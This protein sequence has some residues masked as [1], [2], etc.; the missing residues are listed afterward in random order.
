M[1]NRARNLCGALRPNGELCRPPLANLSGRSSA[2]RGRTERAE[3]AI[4]TRPARGY[5]TADERAIGGRDCRIV[6]PTYYLRVRRVAFERRLG[7]PGI[8][9]REIGI[10]GIRLG[11]ISLMGFPRGAAAACLVDKEMRR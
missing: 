10:G 9:C 3:P 4:C 11:E 2:A 8:Y 6:P 1:A 5:P 7:P